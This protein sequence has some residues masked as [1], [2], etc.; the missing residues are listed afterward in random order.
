M[1]MIVL[2]IIFMLLFF[3]ENIN[4]YTCIS[5]NRLHINTYT[6]SFTFP[7]VFNLTC[8]IV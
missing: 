4:V 6:V 1:F 3:G 5:N 7:D 8:C 2:M